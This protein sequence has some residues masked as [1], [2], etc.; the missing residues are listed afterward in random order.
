[1]AVSAIIP[2]FNRFE[3]LEQTLHSV[4]QQ[5]RRPDEVIVIDDCS[6]ES[7]REQ[8]ARFPQAG[9]L[10]ILRTDRNRRVSGARN[11]G[12]RHATGDLIAFLDSDDLWEPNKI[13]T[14]LDF[15]AANPGIDGVYGSMIAFWPDGRT[16]SW[17]HDRPPTVE[18]KYALIDCNITVQT[19]MIRRAALELLNGFDERFGILDDQEL[20]IR[21]GESGLKIVFLPQP[22]VTRLRRHPTNYSSHAWRYFLEECRI[23]SDNRKLCRRIYGAGSER[24]HLGRALTRFGTQTR[25]MG[26]PTR[27]LARLLYATA[28]SS[29]MPREIGTVPPAE[30]AADYLMTKTAA[31]GH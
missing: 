18:T 24:I 8:L 14:Q 29:K 16:Q 19:L 22:P 5:T 17:A 26:L 21:M 9:E 11:W 31:R 23:I 20:A 15:L 3:Y 6:S 13:Q 27:V 25:L 4:F 28:R 7:L 10:R 12:W 1:L 30:I 2:V